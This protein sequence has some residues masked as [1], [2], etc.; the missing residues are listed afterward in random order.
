[1]A[2]AVPEAPIPGGG[3]QGFNPGG[4]QGF[5]PGGGFQGFNPGDAGRSFMPPRFSNPGR[6]I[7]HHRFDRSFATGGYLIGADGAPFYYGSTLG[8]PLVYDTSVYAPPP[9]YTAPPIYV[10]VVGPLAS[11]SMPAAPARPSV[12][13]YPEGRYEFRGDGVSTPYHWVCIRTSRAARVHVTADSASAQHRRPVAGAP[14]SALSLGRRSGR[15]AP[16]GQRRHRAG[17][18]PQPSQAQ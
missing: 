8:D 9:V 13:E 3:F 2:S 11:N 12:I 10:P 16:D 4:F 7:P 15:G 1:M 18:V 5:N 14:E 6:F 17:A